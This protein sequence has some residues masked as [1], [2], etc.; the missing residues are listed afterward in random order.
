M[1]KRPR[2]LPPVDVWDV[3]PSPTTATRPPRFHR[4]NQVAALPLLPTAA[5]EPYAKARTVF[6][7]EFPN[8]P[9]LVDVLLVSDH[10]V[11]YDALFRPDTMD[12][13]IAARMQHPVQSTNNRHHHQKKKMARDAYLQQREKT[14]LYREEVGELSVDTANTAYNQATHMMLLIGKIVAS[15]AFD[16]L[17][18]IVRDVARSKAWKLHIRLGNDRLIE[19]LWL[20]MYTTMH[21]FIASP[22]RAAT[23]RA[24]L[25]CLIAVSLCVTPGHTLTRKRLTELVVDFVYGRG[26][27]L[28][29]T[30]DRL[31]SNRLTTN[32]NPRSTLFSVVPTRETVSYITR[33]F[34]DIHERL[35]D[36]AAPLGWL[37]LLY[38]TRYTGSVHAAIK[39]AYVL[40]RELMHERH[41]CTFR[42]F[43]PNEICRLSEIPTARQGDC[44]QY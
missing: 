11:Y 32:E 3:L 5:E 15:N 35:F 31:Y 7:T 20:F 17:G 30:L 9:L 40:A 25:T 39:G 37:P 6:Y 1:S 28:T 14:R 41:G 4:H 42:L 21:D 18:G 26:D 44:H 19:T 33:G 38:Q 23:A 12:E 16:R 24:N 22:H 36:P 34:T 29:P 13:F 2:P 43:G 10:L 27:S 8:I